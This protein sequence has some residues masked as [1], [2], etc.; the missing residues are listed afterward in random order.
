M[1]IPTKTR[2]E[3]WMDGNACGYLCATH[4]AEAAIDVLGLPQAWLDDETHWIWDSAM[5]S[6]T[7]ARGIV[8]G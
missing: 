8:W 6:W 7:S 5:L 3:V 4:L 2:I 1:A